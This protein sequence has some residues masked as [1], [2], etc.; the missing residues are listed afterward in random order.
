MQREIKAHVERENRSTAPLLQT[1]SP[2]RQRS[3]PYTG[4]DSGLYALLHMQI[5]THAHTQCVSV[6]SVGYISVL[7]ASLYILPMYTF[8]NT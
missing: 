3:S 8:L 1:S 7:P 2:C 5:N 4:T 6:H